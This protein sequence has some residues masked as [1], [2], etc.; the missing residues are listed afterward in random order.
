MSLL[1]I[2]VIFVEDKR[3]LG[4]AIQTSLMSLLSICVIFVEDKRHLGIEHSN[5]FG[6]SALDLRYLCRRYRAR[7][8]FFISI[9]AAPWHNSFK[10]SLD[11]FCTRLAVNFITDNKSI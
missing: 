1:S 6:V 4:I 9:N 11:G 7:R 8:V 10:I 3:H 2:C 5:K